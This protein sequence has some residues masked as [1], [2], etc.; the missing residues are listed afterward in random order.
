MA[1]KKGTYDEWL[2]YEHNSQDKQHNLH[3]MNA[4]KGTLTDHRNSDEEKTDAE[5][6]SA[7]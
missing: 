4:E 2:P 3:H 1:N 7:A 5:V 6:C